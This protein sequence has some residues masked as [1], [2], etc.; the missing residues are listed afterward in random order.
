VPDPTTPLIL[1]GFAGSDPNFSGDKGVDPMNIVIKV[2]E[3]RK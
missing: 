2:P 1:L 3:K